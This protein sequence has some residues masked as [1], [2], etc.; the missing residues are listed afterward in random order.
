MFSIGEL[1][2]L[3]SL[4]AIS[5]SESVGFILIHDGNVLFN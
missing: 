4:Y 1:S 5:V 3:D 2:P